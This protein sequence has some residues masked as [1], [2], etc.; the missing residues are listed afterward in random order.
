[1]LSKNVTGWTERHG[2][3]VLSEVCGRALSWMNSLMHW[4]CVL[5]I[6]IEDLI[7]ALADCETVVAPL[8]KHTTSVLQP[9]DVGVIGPFKKRLRDLAQTADIEALRE[10][11][12]QTLRE[13]LLARIIRSAT[14]K[15][16]EFQSA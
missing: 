1:M 8:F 15:R 10:N 2:T 12:D 14:Q 9:L 5:T 4:H 7:K 11:H 6:S 3:R 16:K 13:R